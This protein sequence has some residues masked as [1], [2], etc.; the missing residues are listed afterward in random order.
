MAILT[1]KKAGN[2]PNFSNRA[3]PIYVKKIVRVYCR[4]GHALSRGK[5]KTKVSL[6]KREFPVLRNSEN[7]LL[8][9]QKEYQKSN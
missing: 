1:P 9:K 3:S 4:K 2:N 7:S 5:I 6:K 8:F